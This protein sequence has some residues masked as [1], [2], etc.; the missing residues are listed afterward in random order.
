M[1]GRWPRHNHR[2]AYGMRL[3]DQLTMPGLDP[4]PVELLDQIVGCA[5][6]FA[7]A[8]QEDD[9]Q[10]TIEDIPHVL[11]QLSRIAHTVAIIIEPGY[12]PTLMGKAGTPKTEWVPGNPEAIVSSK[13]SPFFNPAT[14]HARGYRFHKQR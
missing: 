11:N 2:K 10:D 8:T 9:P 13:A 6:A 1:A 5:N 14:W 12:K 4:D 7:M 3:I